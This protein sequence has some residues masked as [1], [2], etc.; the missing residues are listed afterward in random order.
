MAS[1]TSSITRFGLNEPFDLQVSRNQITG[2]RTIFRNA[3][4]LVITSGQNYAVWNRAANYT[5]PSSASVMTL[6]S[7]AVG[8]VG[9]AV[10]VSGLDADYNEISEVITLNGTTPVTSVKSFFRIN[11]MLV[12]VDSPTGNIYF[13]TGTVTAGVPANVYG[14]ISAGDNAMMAAVYSVPAG[15]SLYIYGGSINASLATATKLVTVSFI[16]QI[17]GVRY[18]AAKISTSG[19]YQHYPYTPPL[20]IPAKADLLDTATTTDNTASTIT[21]NFS[22]ILIKDSGT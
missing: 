11:D 2:H 5:F 9:Q 12:L 8:D 6:S 16:T 21:A 17:N 15:H 7:S 14:F 3:Y 4:S 18:Q 22:G 13:G 19:G 1:V 20:R 10:L